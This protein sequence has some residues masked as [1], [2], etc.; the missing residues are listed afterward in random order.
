MSRDQHPSDEST[1][2]F[3]PIEGTDSTLGEH[4]VP[5]F[6]EGRSRKASFG[7]ADV[8]LLAHPDKSQL[9]RRFKLP[10]FGELTF[11]R[12][13]K[14]NISLPELQSV[15]RIHARLVHRGDRVLIED[16]RSTNG[17]YV[18]DQRIQL[19]TVLQTGDRFQ[20]GEVHFKFLHEADPELAYHEAIYQLVI[21][22]GLTSTFNK[23][24]LD[25]ELDREV[26]RSQRHQRPLALILFDV[27]HFKLVNDNHGHLCG[28]A[29]LQQIARRVSRHLR[30]EQMLARVGGEE[31]VILSPETEIEGAL[32]LAEKLR[33][34]IAGEPFRHGDLELDI[35]CSFGVAG[36]GDGATGKSE[37]YEAAD[38]AMY[39]SKTGGRNRVSLY[40]PD[41]GNSA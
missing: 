17:T 12:S 40:A 21:R 37:L 26:A 33:S 23:R 8:I 36:L 1:V 11:G 27:D 34:E 15:S 35:S 28:D 9:G 13:S 32:A 29:V 19:P 4:T 38:R 5:L 24:K 6:A 7:H 30:P 31:F 25:E 10:A 20:V 22:D 2:D 16:V 39:R 14:T 18:N 3:D 41:Q